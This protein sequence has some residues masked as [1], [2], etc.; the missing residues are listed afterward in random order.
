MLTHFRHAASEAHQLFSDVT[1]S[2]GAVTS[3]VTSRHHTCTG[4]MNF[5]YKR[6]ANTS[7]KALL[8]HLVLGS[9]PL[10]HPSGSPL[11]PAYGW[12]LTHVGHDTSSASPGW[13][14]LSSSVIIL[15]ALVDSAVSPKG[16]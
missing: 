2:G 15:L 9:R 4:H 8:A 11:S 12:C 10:V 7:F 1:S 6:L 16:T 3:C 13:S 5:Y 14:L